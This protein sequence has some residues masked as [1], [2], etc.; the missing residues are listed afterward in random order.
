MADKGMLQ[1][2]LPL[3][4]L[5]VV[6]GFRMRSMSRPQPLNSGRMWVLPLVLVAAGT[7]MLFA[8]PIS[9]AGWAIS[10]AAL[11][12]GAVLGWHRGKMIRVWKD[13]QTGQAMQQASPAAMLFLLGIIAVRYLVRSYFGV[14]SGDGAHMDPRALIATDA[15][16]VFAIGLVA[17]TR[18][19]LFLR[20][21]QLQTA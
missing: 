9:P 15:L 21:R 7:A 11:I 2:I 5:V 13:P 17:A 20:M 12:G 10:A 6:V 14:D 1:T 8:N 18:L 19:E 4:I 16:L 3:V